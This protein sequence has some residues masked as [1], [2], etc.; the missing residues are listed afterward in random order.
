MQL[1]LLL[2]RSAKG[3]MGGILDLEQAGHKAANADT[4]T[5]HRT[6]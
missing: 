2:L 6:W 1:L 5:D 3:I 4:D